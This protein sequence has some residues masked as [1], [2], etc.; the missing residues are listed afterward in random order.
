MRSQLITTLFLIL[1]L[2]NIQATDDI[3]AKI[4]EDGQLIN[5]AVA[6]ATCANVLTEQKLWI[7]NW[8]WV[9]CQKASKN[10]KN[11]TVI[12]DEDE[13]NSMYLLAF[14]VYD[15]TRNLIVVSFRATTCGD[16]W[17]NGQTDF[18]YF[19]SIYK[20]KDIGGQCKLLT[21]CRMHKGFKQTYNRLKDRIR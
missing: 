3:C 16:N 5:A 20:N 4:Q 2:G 21:G 11:V 15:E 10:V 14:V 8:S 9:E 6:F 19:N 18:L 17:K 1:L 12:T 7:E 13:Q